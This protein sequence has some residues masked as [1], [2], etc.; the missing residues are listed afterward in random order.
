MYR[1][2][3]FFSLKD[4]SVENLMV[5]RDKL[6][7]LAGKVEGLLS[8]EVELDALHSE[9]SCDLCLNMVFTSREALDAYRTHPAHIPVQ[10]HMHAVRSGS[11]AADYPIS[12]PA[13]SMPRLY[14]SLGPSCASPQTL[15]KMLDAGMTGV[16]LSTLHRTFEENA[17]WIDALH[18]AGARTGITP[19]I[20]IA[21]GYTQPLPG[22][23]RS[24]GA[25]GV[26][27]SPPED[28][29]GFKAIRDQ[30][31]PDMHLVIAIVNPDTLNRL[32]MILANADEVA[33][34]RKTLALNAQPYS[35]PAIQKHIAGA[36]NGEGKPF[37]VAADLLASMRERPVPTAAEMHDIFCTVQDGA[38][39]LMLVHETAIGKYPVETMEAL[40][41]AAAAGT[42]VF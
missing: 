37:M 31:G 7:S 21:P 35:I 26:I 4:N 33:I 29:A 34:G 10:Q 3:V 15:S 14:A 24:L 17:P 16:R 1:H 39:A 36:A 20:L 18:T 28:D 6:R 5:A 42:Q 22:N 23:I 38:S 8:V 40:Y 27:L 41:K 12:R 19:E 9:R 25:T 11:H 32:P 13:R 30:I 2:I